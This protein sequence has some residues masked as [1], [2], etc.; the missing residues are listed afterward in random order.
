MATEKIPVEVL[1][2]FAEIR[3]RILELGELIEAVAPRFPVTDGSVGLAS[4]LERM[5]GRQV[6]AAF[7]AAYYTGLPD[8][9]MTST[10]SRQQPKKVLR[11]Q[12]S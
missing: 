10:F 3:G 7:Y 6:R 9:D 1:D 11:K 2:T 8:W 5:E 4:A 12:L